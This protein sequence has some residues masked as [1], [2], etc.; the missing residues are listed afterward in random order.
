MFYAWHTAAGFSTGADP[1]ETARD[2]TNLKKK[3]SQRGL[4]KFF[5]AQGQWLNEDWY[6]L[7][8]HG[9]RTPEEGRLVSEERSAR[10][11][12][13]RKRFLER[14]DGDGAS[15]KPEE[16]PTPEI[17]P[18]PEGQT[19]REQIV[20]SVDPTVVKSIFEFLALE[21]EHRQAA[22]RA[23]AALSVSASPFKQA[24]EIMLDANLELVI[25]LATAAPQE[26][27]PTEG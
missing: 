11:L 1:I 6:E 24:V 17:P 4:K 22:I 3:V 20:L 8:V 16:V 10:Y 27:P 21:E 18:T 15:A 19:G 12:R 2:L 14:L 25:E 23:L 7:A 26:D 13:E 5:S 9:P